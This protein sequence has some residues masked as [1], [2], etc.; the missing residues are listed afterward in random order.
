MNLIYFEQYLLD[1]DKSKG[2]VSTYLFDVQKFI[3]L[4]PGYATYEYKDLS[5]YFA[6]VTDRYRRED[7][8]VTATVGKMLTAIKWFYT[9]LIHSG[10]RE[11]HP[12][13][14]SYRIRGTK[15][16]GFDSSNVFTPKE[17]EYLLRYAKEEDMRYGN[18]RYRNL[19]TISLLVY[20]ALTSEE[21]LQ[22]TV[23]DIDLDA[24]TVRVKKT[25]STN[26][27]VLSLHPSQFMFLHRYL[28]ESRPKLLK[29]SPDFAH[30]YPKLI[31][32]TR[33]MGE[34]TSGIGCFLRRYRALF[35]GKGITATNI[36]KSVIYKWLN[37]DKRSL[38]EVQVW[39]G[40]KWPSTTEG[41]ITHI[42][43]DDPEVINGWH[44]LEF[45]KYI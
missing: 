32:G 21:L 18:L 25:L 1:N 15:K 33:G 43:C 11:E 7:G 16:K 28:H 26:G 5:A 31:I 2:T 37:V 29:L 17:L 9:F 24:G 44:P 35:P 12:F 20:Q 8:R 41:Y 23:S 22:L 19:T 34:T 38:H 39:A 42:D 27:R 4:N 30:I 36:R 45:L 3:D 10:V 14:P 13:P 40:H 6:E